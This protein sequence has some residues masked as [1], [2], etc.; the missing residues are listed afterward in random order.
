MKLAWKSVRTR[1]LTNQATKRTS[2]MPVLTLGCNYIF[3]EKTKKNYV[4][5]IYFLMI[6]AI[7]F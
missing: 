3:K 1:E 7:E 5:E 4:S 2:N 6:C